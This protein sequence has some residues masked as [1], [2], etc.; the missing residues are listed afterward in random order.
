MD[1]E[2][3]LIKAKEIA[4]L[5]DKKSSSAARNSRSKAISS[6]NTNEVMD[7]SLSKTKRRSK[8]AKTI[9]EENGKDEKLIAESEV[10]IKRRYNRRHSLANPVMIKPIVLQETKPIESKSSK[11]R[12]SLCISDIKNVGL[13]LSSNTPKMSDTKLS[14]KTQKGTVSSDIKKETDTSI[15]ELNAMPNVNLN[16][17]TISKSEKHEDDKENISVPKKRGRPP[18]DKSSSEITSKIKFNENSLNKTMQNTSNESKKAEKVKSFK[19]RHSLTTLSTENIIDTKKIKS[20]QM[21]LNS[22]G[23][24]AE[25]SMEHETINEVTSTKNKA[26]KAA[27][28]KGQIKEEQ[29][30][31]VQTKEDESKVIKEKEEVALM[32]KNNSKAELKKAQI[33]EEESKVTKEVDSKLVAATT[34]ISRNNKR[35]SLLNSSIQLPVERSIKKAKFKDV[36]ETLNKSLSC[37]ENILPNKKSTSGDVEAEHGITHPLVDKPKR[38]TAINASLNFITKRPKSQK[39][40]EKSKSKETLSRLNIEEKFKY[41]EEKEKEVKLFLY[42]FKFISNVNFQ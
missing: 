30:N 1:D 24:N 26:N 37:L 42:L 12:K 34:N 32:K 41:L 11:K 5:V 38:M 13:P 6:K 3:K 18:L 22:K 15:N 9:T 16:K 21:K 14:K 31:N 36:H 8:S 28:K 20:K 25:G 7:E 39:E 10:T 23:E 33:K 27:P 35:K 2:L 19:R 40:I 17:D 4:N 29:L